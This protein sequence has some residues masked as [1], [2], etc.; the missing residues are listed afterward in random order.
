MTT[1]GHR[2]CNR[3]TVRVVSYEK[4]EHQQFYG[5]THDCCA[6][7]SRDVRS[8]TNPRYLLKPMR[9]T[10]RWGIWDTTED[11]WHEGE[12]GNAY[13]SAGVPSWAKEADARSIMVR[14]NADTKET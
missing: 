9:P 4:P 13:Y 12:Y 5:Q 6:V 11:T 3:A 7:H 2:G 10:R 1:C 14:L 8:P